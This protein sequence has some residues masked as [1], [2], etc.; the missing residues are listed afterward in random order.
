VPEGW[1]EAVPGTYLRG[2]PAADPT[3][4]IQKS[5]PGMTIDEL[6]A[7]LWPPLGLDELPASMDSRETPAFAW[8]L[9]ATAV[10]VPGA[11]TVMVDLALAETDAATYLVLLQ[12][13][14]DDYDTLHE[15]VLLPVVDALALVE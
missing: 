9:Y 7:V 12:A 13:L 15:A 10:E 4:L 5:Y 1:T 2:T 11:G 14:E 6:T 3:S 8:D